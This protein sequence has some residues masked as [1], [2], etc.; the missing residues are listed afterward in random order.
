MDLTVAN[1]AAPPGVPS[2]NCADGDDWQRLWN[3]AESWQG[4]LDAN[5]AFLRGEM[6]QSP[7][8]HAQI[9]EETKPLVES[10]L[11][12][13]DYGFLTYCSQ[14]SRDD[15]DAYFIER[16][17]CAKC[18][19]KNGYH[20][21]KQR[22]YLSFLFPVG[23]LNPE[24][25]DA[26]INELW[27]DEKLYLSIITYERFCRSG[28]CRVGT[29]TISDFPGGWATHMSR[30]APT[31][32]EAVESEF[33]SS[34]FIDLDCSYVLDAFMMAN[35]SITSAVNPFIF[36]VLAEDWEPCDLAQHVIDA[37]ERAGLEKTFPERSDDVGGK[38]DESSREKEAEDAREEE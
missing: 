5:R 26:F 19:N 15:K 3:D 8:Y 21:R 12:L 34:Q 31:Y 38:H 13:H 14:P 11:K 7:Y 18:G 10:L 25:G 37:A 35:P 28:C 30:E 23:L 20:Q 17:C 33:E 9:S 4:F 29:K 36:H 24:A 27:K 22:A 1:T 2:C 6:S 32:Q 16:D